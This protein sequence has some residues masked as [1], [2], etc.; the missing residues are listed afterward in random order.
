MREHFF[1]VSKKKYHLYFKT[2]I[3]INLLCT[4]LIIHMALEYSQKGLV[5]SHIDVIEEFLFGEEKVSSF[6][7]YS[8]F[9]DFLGNFLKVG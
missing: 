4:G 7:S 6:E 2:L 8:G 5:R 9:R 1:Y 3:I